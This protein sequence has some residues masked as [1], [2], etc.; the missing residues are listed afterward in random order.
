MYMCVYLFVCLFVVMLLLT[1]LRLVDPQ[2]VIGG[3]RLRVLEDN[4]AAG[5][6]LDE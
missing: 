2:V 6:H 5:D 3:G 1:L 4:R